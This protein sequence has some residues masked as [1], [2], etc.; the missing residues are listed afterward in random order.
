MGGTMGERG[1]WVSWIH[2]EDEM[3]IILYA[4]DR[5]V[6]RGPINATAPKPVTMEVFSRQIGRVLGR[7]SWAPV[8]GTAMRIA[9]GE[10]ANVALASQR[11]VPRAVEAAGYRFAHAESGE[12]LR[13]I[14]A[15]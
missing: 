9:L 3:G 14:L 7:P 2:I 13:S 8:W 4:I 6:V 10:R 15:E 11:V 12:A 5:D 1:Q